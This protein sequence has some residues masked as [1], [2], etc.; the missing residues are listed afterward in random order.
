MLNPKYA[1]VHCSYFY[2]LSLNMHNEFFTQGDNM[3]NTIHNDVN[4]TWNTQ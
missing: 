2:K 1:C 3:Y 4:Y